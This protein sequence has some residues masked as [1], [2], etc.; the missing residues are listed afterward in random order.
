MGGLIRHGQGMGSVSHLGH[1]S[2]ATAPGKTA[3]KPHELPTGGASEPQGCPDPSHHSSHSPC[4]LGAE[5]RREDGTQRVR[6]RAD[7]TA[8]KT[9]DTPP[10]CSHACHGVVPIILEDQVC[11]S[12]SE[13][14]RGQKR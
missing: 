9:A 8:S 12:H 3:P 2:P 14:E 11:G 1:V 5:D 10:K 6:A 13:L 7:I 4:C